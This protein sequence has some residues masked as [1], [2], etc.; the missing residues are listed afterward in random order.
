MWTNEN[1]VDYS[2]QGAVFIMR[3]LSMYWKKPVP[4]VTSRVGEP[5]TLI[6]SIRSEPAEMFCEVLPSHVNDRNSSS[7]STT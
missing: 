4:Q 1:E 6:L 3:S 2:I 7:V 5:H